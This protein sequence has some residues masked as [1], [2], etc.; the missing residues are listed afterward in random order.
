MEIGILLSSVEKGILFIKK[1]AMRT[2]SPQWWTGTSAL[3]N[4]MSVVSTKCLF[5]LSVIPFCCGVWK[6]V[7]WC[8]MSCEDKKEER[9][10]EKHSLALSLRRILKTLPNW[11][12]ISLK[13]D[14]KI[15][16]SS[17]LSFH[18]IYP[19]TTRV[20]I[21]ECDKISKPKRCN[22]TGIPIAWMNDRKKSYILILFVLERKTY[23][24]YLIE[25][26]HTLTL[27]L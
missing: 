3:N 1:Q 24:V 8:K 4:K 18:Q 17:N 27:V 6:Q 11:F 10:E 25:M 9:V 23:Y 12:L 15:G 16:E 22:M 19:Y 20:F 21:D 5:F 2:A 7:D 26:I 13:K 14:I